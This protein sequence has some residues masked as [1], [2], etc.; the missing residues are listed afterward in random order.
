MLN[1]AM[2]QKCSAFNFRV[3]F[4]AI[5][6]DYLRLIALSYTHSETNFSNDMRFVNFP[7]S[8]I[9]HSTN[10]LAFHINKIKNKYIFSIK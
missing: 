7:G 10:F 3:P 1:R 4:N 9:G 2:T 6:C 8:A 5:E